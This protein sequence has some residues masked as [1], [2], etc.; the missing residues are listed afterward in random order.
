[1]L[2]N[3]QVVA[4]TGDRISLNA[5]SG[6]ALQ[7]RA[8]VDGRVDVSA[9]NASDRSRP[10]DIWTTSLLAGVPLT[11]PRLRVEGS[12]GEDSLLLTFY[13]AAGGPIME[14]KLVIVHN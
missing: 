14:S 4:N 1:M 13:P 12:P 10:A 2:V 9:I 3:D 6:F 7:V 11:S 5:G 8:R